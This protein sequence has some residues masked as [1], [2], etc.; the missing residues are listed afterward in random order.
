MAHEIIVV[1]GR[2]GCSFQKDVNTKTFLVLSKLA[3]SDTSG[4]IS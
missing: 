2:F 4:I 1:F 3:S